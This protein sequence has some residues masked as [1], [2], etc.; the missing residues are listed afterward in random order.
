[1]PGLEFGIALALNF[2]HMT[3]NFGGVLHRFDVGDAK[4]QHLLPG[5]AYHLAIRLVGVDDA[6]GIVE[7]QETILGGAQDGA[8]FQ[9]GGFLGRAQRAMGQGLVDHLGQKLQM[10]A[11]ALLDQIIGGARLV[12]GQRIALLID[13]EQGLAAMHL[14]IPRGQH[15]GDQA[16]H[17]GRHLDH[18]GAYLSVAGPGFE[19]IVVPQ[20]EAGD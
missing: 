7:H 15:L 9:F 12:Q 6:R 1:M 16:R 18:V 8:V 14:L 5:I 2:R 3:G 19:L 13:D 17:I 10:V 20:P 11:L 4:V